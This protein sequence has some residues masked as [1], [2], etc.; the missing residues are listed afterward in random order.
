MPGPQSKIVRVQQGT[1]DYMNSRQATIDLRLAEGGLAK[2]FP[3][4]PQQASSSYPCNPYKQCPR[5][6]LVQD[7]CV[8]EPVGASGGLRDSFK[9]NFAVFYY[10]RQIVGQQHQQLI[11][12][13]MDSLVSPFTEDK[14][15]PP[16][17]AAPSIP[18]YQLTRCFPGIITFHSDLGHDFKDPNLIVSVAQINFATEGYISAY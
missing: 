3:G 11:A 5:L 1:L 15:F 6:L 12:A 7:T 14:L 13:D 2:W 17:L 9:L 4:K 18:G 16:T 10:R 8:I